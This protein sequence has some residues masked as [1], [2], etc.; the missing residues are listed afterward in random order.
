MNHHTL[1]AHFP[2]ITY[3]RYKKLNHHFV[4]LSE[5]FETAE[6]GDIIK[7]GWEEHIADE[8]IHWREKTDF[9]AIISILEKEQINTISINEEAYPKL[10]AEIPDP[11]H[12][13]FSE[14]L[15]PTK[16]FRA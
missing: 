9:D 1:L 16:T 10:L 15:F 8:F 6:L 2:K 4:N 12:T 3:V 14:E 7:A 5:V 13:L 11:P